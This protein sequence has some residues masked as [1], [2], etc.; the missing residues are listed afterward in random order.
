[1]YLSS[2]P[3][4]HT[5]DGPERDGTKNSALNEKRLEHR[6]MEYWRTELL[7]NS[8]SCQKIESLNF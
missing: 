8:V 2:K 1:M 6:K 7:P 3:A 5:V 4:E